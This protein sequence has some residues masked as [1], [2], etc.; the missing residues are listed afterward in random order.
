MTACYALSKIHEIS[1]VQLFSDDGKGTSLLDD[2][3]KQ[4]ILAPPKMPQSDSAD[5]IA[6]LRIYIRRPPDRLSTDSFSSSAVGAA[7]AAAVAAALD[8]VRKRLFAAGSAR[9]VGPDGVALPRPA[10][11]RLPRH[12]RCSWWDLAGQ[13]GRE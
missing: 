7:A 12:I 5:K 3:A 4:I 10:S 13:Q 11:E 1:N 9:A 8:G 2:I 6:R